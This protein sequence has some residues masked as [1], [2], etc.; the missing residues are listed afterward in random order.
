VCAFGW[1]SF[2]AGPESLIGKAELGRDLL[3]RQE[4]SG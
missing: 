2:Q 3:V 1:E 4:A